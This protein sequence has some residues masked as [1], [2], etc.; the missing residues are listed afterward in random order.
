MKTKKEKNRTYKHELS[1]LNTNVEK[2]QEGSNQLKLITQLN[3]VQLAK[4]N[5]D[6]HR[7]KCKYRFYTNNCKSKDKMQM[8][9]TQNHNRACTDSKPFLI[10]NALNNAYNHVVLKPRTRLHRTAKYR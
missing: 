5:V 7:Y 6:G 9:N 10:E 1:H 2:C 4:E 8:K 3:K